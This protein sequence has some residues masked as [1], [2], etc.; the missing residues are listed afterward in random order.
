MGLNTITMTSQSGKTVSLLPADEHVEF[1]HLN[2]R[3]EPLF[4]ASVPQDTYVSATATIGPE[5]YSCYTGNPVAASNSVV[6][7][8]GYTPASQVT[9]ALPAPISVSGDSLVLSL[10]LAVS[11][12]V[13]WAEPEC[14]AQSPD[15]SFEIAPAFGLAVASSSQLE[16]TGL[17]GVIAS[18]DNASNRLTV[19]ASDGAMPGIDANGATVTW[20]PA[21]WHVA[22]S[23]TT[24]IQG[25]PAFTDLAVGMPI[26]F[27]ASLLPD[28]SLT[29]TRLSAL[30]TNTT[31]LSTSIGPLITIYSTGPNV[32]QAVSESSGNLFTLGVG[33]SGG[34]QVLA[35]DRAAFQVSGV[36]SNLQ[37]L[38]F[39]PSFTSKSMVA[40][41]NS[42]IDT[43]ATTWPGAPIYP[44]LA[45]V[46]L[47]PQTIN[48][49]VTAV[50]SES[51]FDT[52]TISLARYDLFPALAVQGLQTAALTDPNTV[53]SYADSN[54]QFL[55][56]QPIAVG[57]LLRLYGLVFNDNGTLRMDCVRILDG[58]KE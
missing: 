34:E 21:N 32:G 36:L 22:A 45:T 31:T 27:D 7:S 24:A 18:I 8:Y 25:D 23:A 2:G 6:A 41:Q 49:T 58:V 50:S 33:A 1:I 29:A 26:E 52:Y 55:N 37:S 35:Y 10:D 13:R 15:Y 9:V 40:G 12:S 53:I 30:D 5:A 4:T 44:E 56:S 19:Y 48:G 16:M 47:L 54:T 20:N 38:P 46:T 11:Q 28:G 14:P 39:T 42:Y 57:S 43:H 3:S 17:D 51:G